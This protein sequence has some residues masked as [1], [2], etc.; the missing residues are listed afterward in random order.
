MSWSIALVGSP[1]NVARALQENSAKLTDYS[2]VEFDAAL[3]HLVGL[4]GQ[5]FYADASQQYDGGLIR[6]I[7][8]GSGSATR[9]PD[10]SYAP[11]VGSCKVQIESLN[12]RFV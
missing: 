5:N 10:G 3:P 1:A 9:N 8:S 4:V 2:K 11:T 12:A 7:A 6:L